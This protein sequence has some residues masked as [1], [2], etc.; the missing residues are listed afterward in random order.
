MLIR[1]V[2]VIG[3]GLFVLLFILFAGE[4][5]AQI[6]SIKPDTITYPPDTTMILPDTTT[7]PDTIPKPDSLKYNKQ[8]SA[9]IESYCYVKDSYFDFQGSLISLRNISNRKLHKWLLGI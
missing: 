8:S 6:D 4:T 3:A 5:P 7:Y 1:K 2:K 9:K